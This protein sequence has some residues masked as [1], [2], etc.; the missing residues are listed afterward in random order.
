MARGD[1]SRFFGGGISVGA[2]VALA[3][4]WLKHHSILWAI[5]HAVYSWFY[6]AYYALTE[7]GMIAPI[8]TSPAMVVFAILLASIVAIAVIVMVALSTRR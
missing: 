4:S 3:L 1:N 8:P 7:S 5:V 2:L 6:V